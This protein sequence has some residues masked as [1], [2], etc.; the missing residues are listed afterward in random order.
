MFWASFCQRAERKPMPLPLRR[1]E[2]I[3]RADLRRSVKAGRL[4]ITEYN[5]EFEWW[6]DS[7]PSFWRDVIIQASKLILRSI[8]ARFRLL[9]HWV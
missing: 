4:S 6:T 2:D 7:R 1:P 5:R 9:L 3:A 8:Y